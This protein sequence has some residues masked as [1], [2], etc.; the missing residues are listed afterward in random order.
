MKI[1][2]Q[3]QRERKT[4]FKRMEHLFSLVCQILLFME[5]WSW[6]VVSDVCLFLFV[7][8]TAVPKTTG[9]VSKNGDTPCRG[10]SWAPAR[11]SPFW[12]G[13]I[14]RLPLPIQNISSP[15]LFIHERQ[16]SIRTCS[17]DLCNTGC[18]ILMHCQNVSRSGCSRLE[19]YFCCRYHCHC[20][21]HCCPFRRCRPILRFH[22]TL[23]RFVVLLFHG[24]TI[25]QRIE[26]NTRLQQQQQKQE[27][28]YNKLMT[29]QFHK[30]NWKR[31][32][33][34]R[35]VIQSFKE[36]EKIWSGRSFEISFLSVRPVLRLLAF[37]LLFSLFFYPK[38][39]IFPFIL[40]RL[41]TDSGR[42]GEGKAHLLHKASATTFKSLNSDK[43][44]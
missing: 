39:S 38:I 19:R 16:I 13:H 27:N 8:S 28:V 17:W 12:I 30:S 41:P 2:E 34:I 14:M 15:K 29:V 4:K 33:K 36:E 22:S 3:K 32:E 37:F 26:M 40:S 10:F 9:N 5:C 44:Q 23:C 24:W 31:K 35:Y 7:F 21:F 18:R 6:P 1:K 20:H 43:T 25:L 11:I 42:S